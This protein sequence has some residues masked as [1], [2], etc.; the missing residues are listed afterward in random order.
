MVSKEECQIRARLLA[1]MMVTYK[2]SFAETK[3]SLQGI[4]RS[5]VVSIE[6]NFTRSSHLINSCF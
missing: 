5:P 6:F 2:A 1:F 4:L 3:N